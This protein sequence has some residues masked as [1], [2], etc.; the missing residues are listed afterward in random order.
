MPNGFLHVVLYWAMSRT[1]VRWRIPVYVKIRGQW[2]TCV[3]FCWMQVSSIFAVAKIFMCKSFR[4]NQ[5]RFMC[6]IHLFVYLVFFEIGKQKWFYAAS[7]H[8]M[9]NVGLTSISIVSPVCFVLFVGKRQ[10]LASTGRM[11]G[12]SNIRTNI[13]QLLRRA[14]VYKLVIIVFHKD[15]DV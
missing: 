5:G 6:Q 13:L 8:I 4:E 11:S 15:V 2:R 12:G 14:S 3:P 9:K 10:K 7:P 1:K